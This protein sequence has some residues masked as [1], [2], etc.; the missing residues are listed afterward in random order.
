M[1]RSDNNFNASFRV[2]KESFKR[3][4]P[5]TTE[6]AALVSEKGT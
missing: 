1:I 5:L 4:T 2:T 6:E 3:E